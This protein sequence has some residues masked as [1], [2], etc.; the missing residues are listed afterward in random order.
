ME[1]T[2]VLIDFYNLLNVNVGVRGH[3]EFDRGRLQER[4]RSGFPNLSTF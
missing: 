1:I 3:H 4:A 2:G